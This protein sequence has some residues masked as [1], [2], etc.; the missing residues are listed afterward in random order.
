MHRRNDRLSQPPPVFHFFALWRWITSVTDYPHLFRS[1]FFVPSDQSPLLGVGWTLNFEV[2]FY[3]V[4]AAA[5]LVSRRFAPLI[6]AGIVYA[7][8]KANDLGVDNFLIKFYSHGYIHFFLYGIALFYVWSFTKDYLPRWPVIV[9]CAAIPIVSY[10][11]QFVT[12]LWYANQAA[13]YWVDISRRCLSPQHFTP[14]APVPISNGV[15]S[16][17]SATPRMPSI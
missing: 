5:L 7:V 1:L 6:A 8:I 15:R 3:V 14:R 12:P 2:Y 11:S 17:C 4:F 9:A 16:F 13:Q 10:G